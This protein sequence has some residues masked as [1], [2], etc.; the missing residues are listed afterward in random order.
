MK[1]FVILFFALALAFVANVSG[2]VGTGGTRAEAAEKIVLNVGTQSDYPPFNYIDV[3][4]ELKGFD[5]EVI[6]EIDKRLDDYDFDFK[7]LAWDS[8]FLALESRVI[9]LVIDEIAITDERKERFIFSEPYIDGQT[10]ILVKKGRTDIKSLEDLEGKNVCLYV[11]DS[12]IPIVEAFNAEHGGKLNLKYVDGVPDEDILLGVQN[13]LYDAYIHDP[14]MTG[15]VIE[16]HNLQV[17]KVGE[18]IELIK[19]AIVFTKDEKGEKLKSLIDPVIKELK[20]DGTLSAL[21]I[22][23]TGGDYVPK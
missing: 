2:I 13:G 14:I 7:T 10:A 4:D 15:L 17:E 20:E 9:D 22:K 12:Y 16:K 1:K 11:G 21:S 5:V 18:P 6:K 23:W 3:D 8:I 19:M